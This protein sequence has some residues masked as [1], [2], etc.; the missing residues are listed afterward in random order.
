MVKLIQKKTLW[1]SI[2]TF[3][4]VVSIVSLALW[5]LKQ[6]IDFKGGS[7]LEVQYSKSVPANNL[8]EDAFK[9][10]GVNDVTINTSNDNGVIFRFNTVNEDTHYNIVV[11][12]QKQG[13]LTE[14][15]FESIGPVIGEEL[16]SK[17]AWA[18]VVALFMILL[19]I[20]IAFRRV[21]RPVASWKYGTAAVIALF[22]DV[23]FVL[24]GY[25][26]FLRLGVLHATHSKI[27]IKFRYV[28]RR[29]R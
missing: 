26:L 27:S 6:G 12:L 3:L 4:V 2:S 29:L 18:V 23:L 17:S 1:L 7:L 19:Y 5:G 14:K 13:E 25:N 28:C 15:N 11:A 9:S 16:K 8:M 24:G 21:S 10:A 22:H 20:S